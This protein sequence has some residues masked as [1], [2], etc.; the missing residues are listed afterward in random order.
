MRHIYVALN[1]FLFVLLLVSA[2]TDPT[3]VGADLL[4]GDQADVG[5]TDTLSVKATT[6]RIDSVV[7]YTPSKSAAEAFLS[8]LVGNMQD[9]IFGNSKAQINAQ[10]ALASADPNFD[11]SAHLDSIVLVL[12]Y[13][14][15]GLYGDLT[16]TYGVEVHR[17]TEFIDPEVKHYSNESFIAS[18]T[19]LGSKE[20]V[21]NLDSIK[22]RDY[23][24]GVKDSMYQV[25]VP[26][27]LRIP[28]D[29]AFGQELISLDTNLYDG[30]NRDSLLVRYLKGLNIRPT[31]TNHGMLSFNLID[32]SSGVFLYYTEKDTIKKQI[33]FDFNFYWTRQ[34]KLEHD[35]SGTL[36]EKVFDSQS[37]G[38]S[39]VFLQGM[40]GTAVDVEIPFAENLA[41][42]IV[43]KAELELRVASP[44]GSNN[45][46]YDPVSLIQVYYPDSDGSYQ[47]VDDYSLILSRIGFDGVLR[48]YG[49]TPKD[50][51]SGTP[52]VYKINIS[53]FF[54]KVIDKKVSNKLRLKVYNPV[55]QPERVILYGAK[56]PQ[57]GI[58]LKVA[59]TRPPGK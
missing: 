11:P 17:L 32:N 14:K 47:V 57:Y 40:A 46:I 18:P 36:V 16:E 38:D 37:M 26:A 25:K 1:V 6:V 48:Y 51:A 56:Q 59:F 15:G 52:K 7:T 44:P 33:R 29:A 12:P 13:N 31:T 45:D 35:Y 55:Q 10:L 8:Y 39:L 9:P 34:T 21:P 23:T 28:L 5:F 3:E 2:C 58:K 43:N 22:I 49:G 53:A 4:E 50:G 24:I 41:G 20:F 42:L 27:Q 54:Q 19:S 30:S